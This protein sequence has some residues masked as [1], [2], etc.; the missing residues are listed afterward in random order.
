MTTRMS[1]GPHV[2]SASASSHSPTTAKPPNVS[3]LFVGP[4]MSLTATSESKINRGTGNAKPGHNA[5]SL[6]GLP[7]TASYPFVFCVDFR[8]FLPSAP[9]KNQ[10]HS[11]G[12]TC[13]SCTK[14]R[15]FSNFMIFRF[16]VY[17]VV[18][19]FENRTIVVSVSSLA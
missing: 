5:F 6:C 4:F 14:F 15:A 1:R 9:C 10:Q 18:S 13:C 17:F 16:G 12:E 19:T 2:T 11:S 7:L 3:E 8:F